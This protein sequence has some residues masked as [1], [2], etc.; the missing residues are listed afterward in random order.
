[1]VLSREGVPRQGLVGGDH[2]ARRA[3]Y[4]LLEGLAKGGEEMTLYV[5]VACN[6]LFGAGRGGDIEPPDMDRYYE[7]EE[8]CLAVF[9]SNAWE[10]LH[11]VTLL[12][13]L[14]KVLPEKARRMRALQVANE[15]VN[16]VELDESG[17]Y[18]RGREV[19]RAYLGESNGEG[20][21][22]VHAML[23]SHIGKSFLPL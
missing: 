6:G 1:M 23:H 7:L 3:D 17:S 15:V 12:S 19:A 18:L 8:C 22:E 5:E 2:L 10:L 20:Q 16:A 14:A 13:G 9:D 11:D 4:Q 21:A